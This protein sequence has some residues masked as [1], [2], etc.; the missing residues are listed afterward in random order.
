MANEMV[1]FHKNRTVSPL[2][3][4][5][6]QMLSCFTIKFEQ[7]IFAFTLES[8]KAFLMF[9]AIWCFVGLATRTN[10]AENP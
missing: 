10:E 2:E 6:R 4:N 7:K 1:F 5:Q 9:N 3:T 8:W